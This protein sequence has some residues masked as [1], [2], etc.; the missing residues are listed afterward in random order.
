MDFIKQNPRSFIEVLKAANLDLKNNGLHSL[1]SGRASL[2]TYNS[3]LDR[4]FKSHVRWKSH[5]V[6]YGYTE[7]SLDSLLSKNLAT[8]Y[9]PKKLPLILGTGEHG[10]FSLLTQLLKKITRLF[11]FEPSE[12]ENK[13]IYFRKQDD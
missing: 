12:L 2:A 11:S 4:L 7:D 13:S 6:N 3:V 5:K 8:S 9:S 1:W 10:S